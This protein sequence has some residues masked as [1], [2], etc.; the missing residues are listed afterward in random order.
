LFNKQRRCSCRV[1]ADT[2]VCDDQPT[3]VLHTDF[4]RDRA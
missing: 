1:L 3:I 4:F 2:H